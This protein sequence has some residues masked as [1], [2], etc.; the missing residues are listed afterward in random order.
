MSTPDYSR[1][2][3]DTIPELFKKAG[4]EGPSE[5]RSVCFEGNE[6][7]Y[8]KHEIISNINAPIDKVWESYVRLHPAVSWQ[9]DMI[10][11]GFMYTRKSDSYTY[12]DSPYHGLE[13]GQV[14]LVDLK[15][16]GNLHFAVGHEIDE[17][18]HQQ[19]FIKICYLNT[20]KTAGSQWIQ[21]Y[22][23][24]PD[25]TRIVHKTLYQGT[26][27]IRDRLLY[28]IFHGKA[29]HQFHQHMKELILS[30]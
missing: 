6:K 13:K 5:L 2:P 30:K 9:S 15:I 21:F 25:Q 26:S 23:S 14:Y 10:S 27:F 20:G 28:P 12:D 7:N 11:F 18:N 24:G 1:I 17:V 8:L 16:I 29:M 19:K 3:F 4:L 22:E